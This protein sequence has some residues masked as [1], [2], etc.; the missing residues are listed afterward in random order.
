MPFSRSRCSTITLAPEVQF[1]PD[2]PLPA[3]QMTLELPS[4]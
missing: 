2:H 3:S 1:C 4:I